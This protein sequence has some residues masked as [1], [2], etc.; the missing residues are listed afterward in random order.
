MKNKK[1]IGLLLMLVLGLF[2]NDIYIHQLF[3]FDRMN[4][5]LIIQIGTLDNP[6]AK[7]LKIVR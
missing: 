1:A 5:R 2:N 4:N 7:K 6:M 3:I